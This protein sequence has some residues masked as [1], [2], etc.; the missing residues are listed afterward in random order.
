MFIG[1][2]CPKTQKS[3]L[4]VEDNSQYGTIVNNTVVSE[5]NF[6][7]YSSTKVENDDQSKIVFGQPGG[8]L[9]TFHIV[10]T[11]FR[12]I[13]MPLVHILHHDNPPYLS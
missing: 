7:E 12:Y 3:I 4:K 8:E 1:G 10:L 6:A 9:A 5:N 2:E 13:Y 11:V